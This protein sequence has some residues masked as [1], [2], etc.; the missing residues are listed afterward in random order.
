MRLNNITTTK[1]DYR[2]QE[3][4]INS[5]QHV[6]EEAGYVAWEPSAG[7]LD[8]L[9]F[10]IGRTSNSV[11]HTFEALNFYEPFSTTPVF[12]AG[13]QTTDGADTAAV[14]CQNKK[15]DGI[16]IKV[17]EEQ[18]RDT[19]TNHTTEVIGYMV[20][21]FKNSAQDNSNPADTLVKEAEAAD[22]YGDFEIGSDPAASG[23]QYVHVPGWSEIDARRGPKG[24][25]YFQCVRNRLLSH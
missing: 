20:L 9:V 14:R 17:E 6:S 23:G 8:D 10:E 4:E 19:E 25:I 12:L 18:S 21:G 13:M 11:T 15:I 16:E 2:I 3:Q 1:F 5:Q 7:S 22:L 24:G